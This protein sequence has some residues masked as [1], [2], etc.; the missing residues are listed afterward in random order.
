VSLTRS[1][2]EQIRAKSISPVDRKQTALLILDAIASCYA[3]ASTEVGSLFKQWA[4]SD[5]QSRHHRVLLAGALTHIT[6]TDDL[7]RESVTHPGCAVIPVALALGAENSC[8]NAEVL[9]AVT[10]GFEAICRVGMSVGP[11]HYKVWHNTATCGPFGGAMAAAELLDLSLEQC[12]WALGNAGTQSSG[13]WEFLE[14]GAMSKHL[15]AGRAAQSGLMAAELASV[16]ISGATKILE[17]EKGFYS[18][19]CSDPDPS[20]LALNNEDPWQTHRT[21]IKPWPSC[22]HT[23]PAIDAAIELSNSLEGREVAD[24]SVESYQAALDLCDRVSPANEYQAKFSLQHCVASALQHGEVTLNSFG[25]N[26]RSALAEKT[27]AVSVHATDPFKS[28]Y[29]D[30]WGARV[31]VKTSDGTALHAERTHCKGDPELPLDAA[32]MQDKAVRLMLSA[33]LAEAECL[34]ICNAVLAMPDNP[35]ASFQNTS[36]NLTGLIVFS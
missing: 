13:L 16:N 17:G 11:Q 3:G 12:V 28:N 36:S 26:Q 4:G 18:A 9:D 33:G 5:S 15:H 35:E 27:T 31:T 7:H 23:H 14:D 30:A 25:P 10:R 22:R 34:D 32:A 24:V 6:E 8:S 19:L 1:L 29:P 21:S 2:A 20:R